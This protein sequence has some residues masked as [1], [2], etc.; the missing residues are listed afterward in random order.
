MKSKTLL[1][2][3]AAVLA[4]GLGPAG[5]TAVAQ[6]GNAQCD[7][8]AQAA[9]Q[10]AK[11]QVA[12]ATSAVR[13]QVVAAVAQATTS[14]VREAVMAPVRAQ[15]AAVAAVAQQPAAPRPR[16]TIGIED[17]GW[18]GVS[19]DDVSADRAKELK[20]SP[21]RGVYVDE[22]EKDSPAEKAGLKPGDVITEFNGEHVEGAV[23]FRRL[24]RETPPGHTVSISIWRDG[25][26][27]TL[28]AT[29]SRVNDQFQRQFNLNLNGPNFAFNM[30]ELEGTVP[31]PAMPAMPEIAPFPQGSYSFVPPR[32]SGNNIF[33]YGSTP[34]IGIGTQNLSGQ[35]GSYFGAPDGEGV[36]VEDVQ[37][38][39]P[40][41]KAG[42]KAG[43]V[44]TK[45]DGNR[46]RTA[47]DLQSEL[48]AKKEDKSVQLTVV[49]HGSET[50]VTVEPNKPKTAPPLRTH[51][52]AL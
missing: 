45:L 42:L 19:P 24:V 2:L 25:R 17:T 13:A 7:C 27:Q 34:T 36:L 40:A 29:L 38:G 37:S 10:I 32:G 44:I 6:D 52:V 33:I 49:R 28:T 15:I 11:A 23:Q 46:V 16:V 4:L 21:A 26:S 50:T 18:L 48:R 3:S 35:L 39:S 8:A 9:R 43:D 14:A 47:G 5:K 1:A 22:V 31:T 20:L 30:P 41:E 51:P 12:Q